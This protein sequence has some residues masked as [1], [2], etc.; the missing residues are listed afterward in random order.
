MERQ[1]YLIIAKD[2]REIM[3]VTEGIGTRENYEY[4]LTNAKIGSNIVLNEYGLTKDQDRAAHAITLTMNGKH[5][6]EV[7]NEIKGLEAVLKGEAK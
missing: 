5:F 3:S 1:F 2:A 6:A 4:H 7:Q